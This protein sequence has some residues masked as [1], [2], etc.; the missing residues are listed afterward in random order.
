MATGGDTN[1]KGGKGAPK[2]KRAARNKTEYALQYAR[3]F[4]NKLR[5][6]R[7]HNGDKAASVY[8]LHFSPSSVKASSSLTMPSA[9]ALKHSVKR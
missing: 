8:A 9:K 2:L 5:R 4:K 7:K 6:V 3:T 1:K